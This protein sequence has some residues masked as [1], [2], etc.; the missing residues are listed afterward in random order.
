MFRRHLIMAI[1]LGAV[2]AWAGRAFA[3]GSPSDSVAVDSAL[4]AAPTVV[5]TQAPPVWHPTRADTLMF[6]SVSRRV[7][8]DATVR[9]LSRR[10]DF[11][12]KG[13]AM[14]LRGV[15]S[16]SQPDSMLPWANVTKVQMR[17]SSAG[18]GAIV[19]GILFGAAGLI[20]MASMT[21]D[22]GSFEFGCGA[23]SGDVVAGTLGAFAIG[24]LVGT[25]VAAPFHHWNDVP[26]D[27]EVRSSAPGSIRSTFDDSRRGFTLELSGGPSWARASYSGANTDVSALTRLRLG[28]GFSERWSAAYVNDVTWSDGLVGITGIGVSRFT[29]TRTP[30]VAMELVGGVATVQSSGQAIWS[31]GVQ[32]G[33]GFEFSRH[34]LMRA[35]FLHASFEGTEYNIVGT[36]IGRLWY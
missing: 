18:Q 30:S 35:T 4:N 26:V 16:S 6:Q 12:V 34:W 31:V 8:P 25:V 5:A 13:R 7:K 29:T 21:H 20:G 3:E 11:E 2:S 28:H 9:V 14:T 24:T 36:S 27:K 32:A 10:G 15:R 19:G 22:C 17:K 23:S 1:M 33:L